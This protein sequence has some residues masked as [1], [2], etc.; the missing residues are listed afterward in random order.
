MEDDDGN[1]KILLQNEVSPTTGTIL[2]SNTIDNISTIENLY[3]DA[4][5]QIS[6]INEQ[7]MHNTNEPPFPDITTTN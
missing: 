2:P 4:T 7:N 5:V 1:N 3:D 6:N